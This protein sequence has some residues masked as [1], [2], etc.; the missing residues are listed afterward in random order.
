[1]GRILLTFDSGYGAT[2]AV[3]EIVAETL[4]EKEMEIDYH[5]VGPNDSLPG[6]FSKYD[7]VV[8]GSPI[9]LGRC[10]PKIRKFLAGRRTE[11]ASTQVAFF[12][13]C[14]SVTGNE[15]TQR[16]PLYIDPSFND[17]DRPHARIRMMEKN[18]AVSYYLKHFL[19]LIPGITPLAISFF[20]GNLNTEKLSYF[21]QLIMRFAM[22]ALPEIRKGDFVNSAVV[23]SWA[24]SLVSR[25]DRA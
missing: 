14:M 25:M 1:M 24:E 21:H 20:K 17:P 9:R 5:P 4:R 12:F 7:G 19:K 22:F 11:L 18:H 3:A 10:T 8:V 2:A 16:F 13:T 15:S 6:D 23:R